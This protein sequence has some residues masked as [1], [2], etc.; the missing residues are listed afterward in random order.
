MN[1]KRQ[2]VEYGLRVV[3]SLD[4]IVTNYSGTNEIQK[5]NILV[6]SKRWIEQRIEFYDSRSIVDWVKIARYLPY[7][8]RIRQ[9]VGDLYLV[10]IKK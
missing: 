5:K 9:Y 7:Y 3:D 1:K 10:K 2:W 6:F 8:D 4:S